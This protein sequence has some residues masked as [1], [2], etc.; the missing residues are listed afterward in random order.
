MV[1]AASPLIPCFSALSHDRM[2]PSLENICQQRCESQSG[3]RGSQHLK[4][5]HAPPPSSILGL[6][7]GTHAFPAHAA[8]AERGVQE[9]HA[10]EDCMHAPHCPLWR[11]VLPLVGG[12]VVNMILGCMYSLASVVPYASSY[13][14]FKGATDTRHSDLGWVFTAGLVSVCIAM[15]YG[16][17]VQRMVGVARCA[18][19]GCLLMSVSFFLAAITCHSLFLFTLTCGVGT[20][21]ALGLASACP[22]TAA[23][24]FDIF[25]VASSARGL[26]T[27]ELPLQSFCRDSVRVPFF[28]LSSSVFTKTGAL[29]L[30]HYLGSTAAINDTSSNDSSSSRSS[31]RSSRKERKTSECCVHCDQVYLVNSER[32]AFSSTPYAE[33]PYEKYMIDPQVLQR[34]PRLF[35]G[36][37]CCCLLLSPAALLLNSQG[38]DPAAADT[39]SSR[40]KHT[41]TNICRSSSSSNGSSAAITPKWLVPS[42]HGDSGEEAL[43]AEEQQQLSRDSPIDQWSLSAASL[44]ATSSS[45]RLAG[46]EKRE[47]ERR[48]HL[49]LFGIWMVYVLL[50]LSVHFI[51]IFWESVALAFHATPNP[52][53]SDP[54]AAALAEAQKQQQQQQ[55]QVVFPQ[56][57]RLPQEE[58]VAAVGASGS[59]AGFGGSVVGVAGLVGRIGWGVLTDVCGAATAVRAICFSLVVLLAC[60]AAALHSNIYFFLAWLLLLNVCVGGISV[61]LPLV[62][63]EASSPADFS[64]LYT[65]AYTSKPASAALSSL[66]LTLF[67]PSVGLTG[68]SA[69]AAGAAFVALLVCLQFPPRIFKRGESWSRNLI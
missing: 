66:L 47:S 11:R 15:A 28:F 20:G 8:A 18:A 49:S 55:Q 57:S 21:L 22:L 13:M 23:Y 46:E 52:S 60:C 35:W 19:L 62:I 2:S 65:L 51:S 24:L 50:G 36:L 25:V 39:N 17:K 1:S 9:L 38:Q 26:N 4:Q 56:L 61:T 64:W 43:Y 27:E 41:D 48:Q 54:E 40:R 29:H 37:G 58:T 32:A 34:V 16:D 12:L 44:S 67:Y 3:W 45:V 14:R 5:V 53:S 6:E 59:L 42:I 33:H 30:P 68:C 31:S 69:L 63:A 7:P 10:S